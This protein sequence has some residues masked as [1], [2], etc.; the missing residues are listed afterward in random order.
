[1]IASDD[2]FNADNE[3]EEEEDDN[4]QNDEEEDINYIA[5]QNL[6]EKIAART[7]TDFTPGVYKHAINKRFPIAKRGFLPIV[8]EDYTYTMDIMFMS[9][10]LRENTAMNKIFKR[11]TRGIPIV[12]GHGQVG[13]TPPVIGG[14]VLVETTS[15]K[16][17]FYKLHSKDPREVLYVFKWFL[18][19]VDGKIA[20][21]LSDRG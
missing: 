14:L 10:V 3:Y 5:N 12:E 11:Q 19:D 20:R 6:Y 18:T 21:L 13:E 2:E 16:I 4:E 1:M 7:R 15:R 8:A 17:F 9:V